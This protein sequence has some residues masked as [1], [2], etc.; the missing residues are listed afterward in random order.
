MKWRML[1]IVKGWKGN[2]YYWLKALYFKYENRQWLSS[3]SIKCWCVELFGR[4]ND[5]YTIYFLIY[6]RVYIYI[7]I[8]ISWYRYRNIE[9]WIDKTTATKKWIVNRIYLFKFRNVFDI[10]ELVMYIEWNIMKQHIVFV[11]T[12]LFFKGYIIL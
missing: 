10:W 12:H 7:Y 5:W 11:L 4:I 1:T 2:H 8:C 3:R 9:D 6:I